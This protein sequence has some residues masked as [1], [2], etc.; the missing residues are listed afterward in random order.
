MLQNPKKSV[1]I[2]KTGTNK[3]TGREIETTARTRTTTEPKRQKRA[4]YSR[5]EDFG[6]EGAASFQEFGGQLQGVQNQLDLA[7]GVFLPGFTTHVGSTVVQHDI[8]LPALQLA[9]DCGTALLAEEE[10]G[11][12][13][14]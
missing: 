10:K 4:A 14:K 7:I 2:L 8:D 13:E 3:G 12:K 11:K 5:T 1:V 6:D 9:L